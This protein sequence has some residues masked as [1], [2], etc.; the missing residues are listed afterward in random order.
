[1]FWA[2]MSERSRCLT[3]MSYTQARILKSSSLQFLIL[4]WGL[5]ILIFTNQILWAQDVRALIGFN[6][7]WNLQYDLICHLYNIPYIKSFK[8]TFFIARIDF[9]Q[10]K[11][12]SNEQL[13]YS[14]KYMHHILCAYENVHMMITRVLI[15]MNQVV[16][17]AYLTF[18]KT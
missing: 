7:A 18:I 6:L 14:S 17:K 12:E 10:N 2:P 5:V 15:N 3:S 4:C 16:I 8:S 1:M 13:Q 11:L 9:L